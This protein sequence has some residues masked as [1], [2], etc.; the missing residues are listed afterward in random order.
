MQPLGWC[1]QHTAAAL[2]CDD[3]ELHLSGFYI[4]CEDAVGAGTGHVHGCLTDSTIGI[5][6]EQLQDA[7]WVSIK[8]S[9]RGLQ[10]AWQAERK[11]IPVLR[12]TDISHAVLQR[13]PLVLAML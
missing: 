4:D 9:C 8:Q 1:T 13:M 7:R 6:Q 2:C 11:S 5:S 12:Q 10:A 3:Y